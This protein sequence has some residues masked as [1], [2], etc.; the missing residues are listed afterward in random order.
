MVLLF[1]FIGIAIFSWGMVSGA[2]TMHEKYPDYN[3]DDLFGEDEI[4]KEN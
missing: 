4:K 1:M 3:G 2:E